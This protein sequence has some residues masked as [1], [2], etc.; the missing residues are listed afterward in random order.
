MRLSHSQGRAAQYLVPGVTRT[1]E[2]FSQQKHCRQ[3]ALGPFF[4]YTAEQVGLPD[5]HI[6]DQKQGRVFDSCAFSL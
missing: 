2:V 5:S 1:G 6:A 4:G 3:T